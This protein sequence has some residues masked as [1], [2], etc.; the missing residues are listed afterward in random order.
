M[1]TWDSGGAIL[2]G[3]FGTVVL[4][5]IG[6]LVTGHFGHAAK[7]GDDAHDRIDGAVER[8]EVNEKEFLRFQTHVAENYAK[9]EQVVRLENNI[10]SALQRLEVK[11]DGVKD[12]LNGDH[13]G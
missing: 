7:K 6:N 5:W 11:V 3:S 1:M 9:Q 8:M 2:L 13:H 12:K 10:F 4:I